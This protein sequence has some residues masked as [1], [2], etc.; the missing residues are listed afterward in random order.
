[1]NAEKV[2][3]GREKLT[4]VF[5]YLEAL[6]QHRNPAKRQ[7]REQLWSLWLHDL[8]D[9]S[10]IKR[11]A[12]KSASAKSKT[13]DSQNDEASGFVLKV[14][15]PSLTSPPEPPAAIATWLVS[16][17]DD[18][19]NEAFLSVSR[20]ASDHGG[21][22]RTVDFADDPSRLAALQR[23]RVGR[24][25]CA[26]SEKPARAAMKIFE[27]LCALFGRIDREAERVTLVLGD[28]IRSCSLLEGDIDH[29]R[30]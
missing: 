8:P 11:G 10:S 18:P 15:R 24:E 6:N 3:V 9:H 28:V 20:N 2:R 16:G 22:T 27:T 4:G 29:P 25:E 30:L 14:Q 19:S 1:M 12:S 5:R 17:W 13:A 7:I 23:W 21:E 26:K